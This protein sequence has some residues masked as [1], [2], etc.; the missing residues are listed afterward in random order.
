MS[1]QVFGLDIGRSF[2]SAARPSILRQ[3]Q[4]SGRSSDV[5]DLNFST[6]YTTTWRDALWLLIYSV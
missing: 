3:A 1:S 5:N 4:D 2:I 6:F